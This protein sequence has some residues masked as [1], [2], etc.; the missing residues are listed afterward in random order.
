MTTPCLLTAI[1]LTPPPLFSH[2]A[3]AIIL[4][5]IVKDEIKTL[6]TLLDSVKAYVTDYVIVDTGS[7]DGTPRMLEKRGIRVHHKEFE[8]FGATRNH[9]LRLA[10]EAAGS[11]RA[12]IML[13]DA[14]F[15]LV[16]EDK[17]RFLSI[18]Q[19][20]EYDVI[21]MMQK[22]DATRYSNVRLVKAH[23]KST[24]WVGAV[25]E[26]LYTDGSARMELPMEVSMNLV[27]SIF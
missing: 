15:E 17:E 20:Y 22:S 10:E 7:T 13:V 8:D 21:T 5:L 23:L 14:D 11:R 19:S 6:P 4:N 24:H 2:K 9:A 18:L 27:C 12:Y 26:Y 25:H 1:R 3:T 16:V